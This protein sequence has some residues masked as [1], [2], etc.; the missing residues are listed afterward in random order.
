MTSIPKLTIINP[1]SDKYD[2]TRDW[3]KSKP[4][5]TQ[6]MAKGA[7][8]SYVDQIFR[9]N[10]SPEKS[11]PSPAVYKNFEAW[12]STAEK[13]SGTI[14]VK[15]LRTTFMLDTISQANDTP[16]GNKYNSAAPVRFNSNIT[17][18]F[19]VFRINIKSQSTW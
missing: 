6:R 16:A 18:F 13:V 3:A 12:K 15:D 5:V 19:L 4:N 9:K 10:K 1:G 2:T 17:V 8:N 11:S 7:V 14:K